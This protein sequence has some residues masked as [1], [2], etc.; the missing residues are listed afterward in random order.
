MDL[1][2]IARLMHV[3]GIAW[4]VGGVTVLKILHRQAEKN[5]EMAPLEAKAMPMISK[6]IALGLLF[7]IIS[8]ITFG[9]LLGGEGAV[10]GKILSIKLV[11]VFILIINGALINFRFMPK[12]QKLAPTNG[13]PTA[14][15]LKAKKQM[16][17]SGTVSLVLWYAIVVLGILL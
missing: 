5:P 7:L 13:T 14:D 10:N 3:V 12:M 15:F 9:R 17:M 8:G 1:L 6:L 11:L 4:G 16:A 2:N